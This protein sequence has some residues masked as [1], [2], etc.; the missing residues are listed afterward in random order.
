M[1]TDS[2]AVRFCTVIE[3]RLPNFDKCTWMHGLAY[4]AQVSM[5]RLCAVNKMA[6]FGTDW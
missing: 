5:E 3:A 6:C 1:H 4:S 2:R